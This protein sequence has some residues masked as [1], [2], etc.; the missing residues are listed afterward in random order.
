MFFIN[1]TLYPNSDRMFRGFDD[2]QRDVA[3][4]RLMMWG[5]DVIDIHRGG[6][7]VD[8]F[9]G[10]SNVVIVC[11]RAQTG[12]LLDQVNGLRTLNGEVYMNNVVYD[13][14]AYIPN[15]TLRKAYTEI[16]AAFDREDYITVYQL[17][18]DAFRW[19]PITGAE[20][21]ALKAQDNN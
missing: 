12:E 16:H 7:L 13:T 20:W 14:I 21:R 18:D 9:I 6:V 5:E 19:I 4:E 2:D 3:G 17:F 1:K 11:A 10:A 15:A 8:D